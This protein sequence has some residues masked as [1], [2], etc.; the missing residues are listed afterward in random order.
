MRTSFRMIVQEITLVFKRMGK[1][2]REALELDS[3][4]NLVLRRFL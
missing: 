2:L 3:A 1:R 4:G